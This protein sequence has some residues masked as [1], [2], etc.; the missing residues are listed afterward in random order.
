M[1]IDDA[2]RATEAASRH[3][4]FADLWRWRL[5]PGDFRA[6]A[7]L[8]RIQ[9]SRALSAESR[10]FLRLFFPSV[11]SVTS[12]QPG[13]RGLVL[14]DQSEVSPA[15]RS[16]EGAD[17]MSGD[18]RS[19]RRFA[20]GAA[21]DRSPQ[22]P[23]ASQLAEERRRLILG[24]PERR[25]RRRPSTDR[26]LCP[27]Q[28]L[29]ETGGAGAEPALPEALEQFVQTRSDRSSC[30][31]A[32]LWRQRAGGGGNRSRKTGQSHRSAIATPGFGLVLRQQLRAA[33][34]APPGEASW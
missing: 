29:E 27:P 4:G 33:D 10:D 7:L 17:R 30:A 22:R 9:S 15:N 3:Y 19:E 5:S 18:A 8:R 26:E 11:N 6:I 31:A 23:G 16:A 32:S 25:L 2:Q 34:A 20:D 21:W 24:P 14:W 1:R 28:R 12:R 13:A